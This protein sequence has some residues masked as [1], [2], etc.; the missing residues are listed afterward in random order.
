MHLNQDEKDM[1]EGKHGIGVANAMKILVGIGEAFQAEKMSKV[2]RVHISLSNQ[3]GDLWF[4]KK[5]V[6]G[7]AKCK[8]M[9][10]VN[11]AFNKKYFENICTFTPQELKVHHQQK[12]M[13]VYLP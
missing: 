5:L 11:P 13:F 6:E 10:T 12:Q 4:V 7:G 2:S 3:E 1:L 8:V 9:S